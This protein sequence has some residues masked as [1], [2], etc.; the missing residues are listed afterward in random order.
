MTAQGGQITVEMQVTDPHTVKINNDWITQVSSRSVSSVNEV[1]TIQ[2]N[3][4]ILSRTGTI[5]FTMNGLTETV[6]IVQEAAD[7]HIPA[8][9]TGMSSDAKT[10]AAKI[11]LGWNLGNT[12]KCLSP[13]AVKP[14]GKWKTPRR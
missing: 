13:V 5:T 3:A 10:L 9:Q 11:K 6:T 12:L 7:A 2:A 8:D 14:V 1:F 4:G